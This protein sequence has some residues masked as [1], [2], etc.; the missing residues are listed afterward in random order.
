M[1]WPHPAKQVYRKVSSEALP[2]RK[3]DRRAHRIEPLGINAREGIIYAAVTG[4]EFSAQERGGQ[5]VA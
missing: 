5:N 1:A 3:L 4:Q 2:N